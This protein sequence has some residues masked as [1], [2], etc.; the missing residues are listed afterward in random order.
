V[1]VEHFYVV[2]GN[3]LDLMEILQDAELSVELIIDYKIPTQPTRGITRSV[4][5]DAGLPSLLLKHAV[6]FLKHTLPVKQS[7]TIFVTGTSGR[8]H[9]Q[10]H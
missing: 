5:P 4:V 1:L 6:T 8:T 3:G 2:D 10:F 7:K 9:M